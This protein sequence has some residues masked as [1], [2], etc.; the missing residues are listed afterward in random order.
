MKFKYSPG[1][2]GYGAKGADGETGQ[3]GL[4]LYFT[5]YDTTNDSLIIKAAIQSNEDLWIST[6]PG[7]KLPNGRLYN[8]GDLF[9]NTAGRVFKIINPITGDFIQTP[10]KL[11]TDAIFDTENIVSNEFTRY[12][13]IFDQSINYIIDDVHSNSVVDYLQNPKNIYGITPKNF[14]KVQYVDV[15]NSSVNAFSL[16]SSGTTPLENS[17]SFAIVKDID[18][19]LFRIGNIDEKG[20]IRDT[21]L[22]FDVSSLRKKLPLIKSEESIFLPEN[23][24]LRND[25]INANK[26]FGGVFNFSPKSFTVI[27]NTATSIQIS[28]KIQDFMQSTSSVYSE[29]YFYDASTNNGFNPLVFYTTDSSG[30]IQIS[31]LINNNLYG[32]YMKLFTNGWGRKSVSRI[33]PCDGVQKILYIKDP[34]SKILTATNDGK[35][36]GL[37]T[38]TVDFSTN[39]LTGW[40]T[41]SSS[42]ITCTPSFALSYSNAETFDVSVSNMGLAKPRTGYID[43]ISQ[44]PTE[45]IEVSQSATPSSSSTLYIDFNNDGSLNTSVLGSNI[46]DISILMYAY[47]YA[48]NSPDNQ[49]SSTLRAFVNS[50]NTNTASAS[51]SII[52]G[53]STGADIN[54]FEISLKNIQSSSKINF[55]SLLQSMILP[56]S[57]EIVDAS[58][59][60]VVNNIYKVSGPDIIDSSWNAWYSDLNNGIT[61]K[62]KGAE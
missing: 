16:F 60:A 30:T 42:W 45:R 35:I 8:E 53:I 10:G 55:T 24:I 34:S 3:Q 18:S 2:F 59:K 58:V 9:V 62:Y 12:Y 1:L 5:D 14:T 22:I 49:V 50:S 56:I 39:S 47:A 32:C 54:L 21:E 23:E 44:A 52:S 11:D 27:S 51:S 15:I 13:N 40:S 41:T 17:R 4:M 6:E 33:I 20:V 29:I 48:D 25:I 37:D 26:L 36:D 57:G 19:N 61:Q 46:I 7:T 43:I 31:N 38:Y 28:W